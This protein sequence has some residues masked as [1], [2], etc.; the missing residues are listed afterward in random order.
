M[1]L[2]GS[3]TIF[4]LDTGAAVTIMS[5]KKFRQ[6]FPDQLLERSSIDLKTYTGEPMNSVG[7]AEFQVSYSN[8]D[9]KSLPLVVVKGDGPSL[10]GRNWLQHFVL[11]WGRN[12][13]VLLENDALCRL[14]QQYADVFA[15]ELGTIIP[16]KAKL[17]V[18]PSAVPRFHR[19]RPVPY[20]L[21]PLVEQE[22]DRLERAGV[23]KQ[24]DHSEWAAPIVMVPKRDGQVRIYG[25]YKVT[26]NAVL[27][28]D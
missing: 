15:D 22:L 25:N 21:K 26:I 13:S 16:F 28:V 20:A 1:S 7:Q 10:L 9:S 5:E 4:E 14:L 6:L 12:K 17:S 2:N 24:V 3:S 19:P 18:S 11:D 8:Q 27:D 23:L